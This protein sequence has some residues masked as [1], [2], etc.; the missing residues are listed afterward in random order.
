MNIVHLMA[1]PFVGGPERQVL[2]LAGSLPAHYQT[3]FLSFTE[4]GLARPFLDRA[5]A[6]GFQA[7]QL[8]ANAPRLFRAAREVAGWLRRLRADVLCCSGYKPDLIGWLAARRSGVPVLAVAHGW[9]AA[10]FK[11]R[12]YEALD[13]WVMRRMDA[14]VCVSEAQAVKVRRAGVRPERAVVIRNA[15]RTE[16]FDH[17]DLA[18][19]EKLCEL[20]PVKPERVVVAAGRLSP[21]KGFDQLIEAAALLAPRHPGAGFVV[22]GEGPLREALTR[23]IAECG[24][25]GR[26]ILAGFH[27]D[28]E[29]WLPWADVGVLSSHTEG[30]PVAVLEAMA[31]GLPVVATA[32]GGT[33][34]VVD[35]GVTGWLTPPG[36][37]AALARRLGDVLEFPEKGRAMG[38]AGRRR[39]RESF[40]FAAQA[41]QY[42]RLFERLAGAA[43]LASGAG[44]EAVRPAA[45]RVE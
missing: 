9:T 24:L 12:C 33:P 16:S 40:T 44:D 37:P 5:R 19:R 26:F 11:V 38:Q 7:F 42:Q 21:E 10:T 14:V 22:F 13:R 43:P 29:R 41:E 3:V 18:Y 23:R 17:P 2:G 27:T 34:E 4:R 35:D 28:L 1:S 39:V 31:A 32:V 25:A 45:L 6:D 30:L 8:E 36:D 20:F 15:L